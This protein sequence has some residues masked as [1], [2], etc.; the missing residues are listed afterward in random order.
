MVPVTPPITISPHW[1]WNNST[2]NKKLH[3]DWANRGDAD[4]ADGSDA[5][6][7][8]SGGAWALG[9]R[10]DGIEEMEGSIAE[11]LVYDTVLSPEQRTS[12]HAYLMKK[13]SYGLD[14]IATAGLVAHFDASKSE[15]LL[16][17]ASGC[18]SGSLTHAVNGQTP[19]CFRDRS[20][21]DNHLPKVS[22]ADG[23]YL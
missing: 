22:G 18:T 3:I 8:V 12:V 20:G 10:I 13:W 9:S 11:V 23:S 15:S 7:L 4:I 1:L 5:L 14:G 17:R 19:E 2:P 16:Q 6:N 21:M